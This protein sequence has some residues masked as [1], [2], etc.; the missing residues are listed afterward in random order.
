M[1]GRFWSLHCAVN[2]KLED[3]GGSMCEILQVV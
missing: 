3:G 2:A 1:P